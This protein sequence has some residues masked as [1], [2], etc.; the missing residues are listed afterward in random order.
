MECWTL[1]LSLA[2]LC[3]AGMAAL[4]AGWAAT[5]ARH[6]NRIAIHHEKLRIYKAFVDFRSKL[7]AYG[8]SVPESDLTLVLFPHVQLVEFYYSAAASTALNEFYGCVSKMVA[9]REL[10]KET[11]AF[12]IINSRLALRQ[13]QLSSDYPSTRK[14]RDRLFRSGRLCSCSGCS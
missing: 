1:V 3:V 11:I 2:S 9:F 4:F 6:Q 14:E 7:K 13:R 8:D 5:A 10:A 12:P